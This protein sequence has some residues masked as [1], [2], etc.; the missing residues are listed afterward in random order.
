[1]DVQREK[2]K[3]I[4]QQT[5]ADKRISRSERTAFGKVLKEYQHDWKMF[6]FI[7]KTAFQIAVEDFEKEYSREAFDWL[8]EMNRLLDNSIITSATA[9]SEVSFSPGQDCRNKILSCLNQAKKTIDICVF[10]ITDNFIREEIE[11]ALRRECQIRIITDDEKIRNVGSDIRRL[12]TMG[13]PIKHDAN[14]SHMHHKFAIFDQQTL[15]TGSFNWTRSATTENQENLLVLND[16]RVVR[17]FQREFK[18]L[19]KA[20][21]YFKVM[22]D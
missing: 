9:I 10:T 19:W 2:I 3:E 6:K 17:P 16:P 15:L 20:F 4:L 18:K 1:M 12:A 7:R 22:E 13:I 14:R 21:P 8:Q 11:L 5:F